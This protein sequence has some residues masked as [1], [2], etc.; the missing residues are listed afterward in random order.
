V[1]KNF[2][3]SENMED[4]VRNRPG[5]PAGNDDV[6]IDWLYRRGVGTRETPFTIDEMESYQILQRIANFLRRQRSK[7]QNPLDDQAMIGIENLLPNS[8]VLAYPNPDVPARP[9]EENWRLRRDVF[10]LPLDVSDEESLYNTVLPVLWPEDVRRQVW[11]PNPI[12]ELRDSPRAKLIFRLNIL[13]GAFGFTQR[14]H[15]QF[16]LFLDFPN[17]AYHLV[18]PYWSNVVVS[19]QYDQ[20]GLTASFRGDIKR[21]YREAEDHETLAIQLLALIRH[22]I[23]R[24]NFGPYKSYDTNQDMPYGIRWELDIS[25]AETLA[26]LRPPRLRSEVIGSDGRVTA[27]SLRY[28]GETDGPVGALRTSARGRFIIGLNTFLAA[29]L[30][31]LMRYH[32]RVKT[33]LSYPYFFLHPPTSYMKNHLDSTMYTYRVSQVDSDIF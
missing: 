17:F 29:T 18:H 10:E 26:V 9:D 20:Y 32:E 2:P 4:P 14:Y 24:L 19:D 23:T 8:N 15:E 16:S 11:N 28:W 12:T 13:L 25:E 5:P 21:I 6:Q 3:L 22:E 33:M 27:D 7:N 30:I 1:C 31:P